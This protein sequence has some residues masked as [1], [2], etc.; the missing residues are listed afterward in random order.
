[1]T[2]FQSKRPAAA[3]PR[4]TNK[5]RRTLSPGNFLKTI[6]DFL[7]SAPRLVR[8]F[9][10]P[11][12]PF[13]LREKIYLAVTSIN[14]CRFCE[15]GHSHW[16]MAHGMSLDAVNEVLGQESKSLEAE[17]SAEAVAILFARHY[18]EHFDRIDPE[19]IKNLRTYYSEVQIKEIL[20]HVRFITLTNLSG[21][22]V[23][24]FLGR[25]RR[26]PEP[27]TLFQFVAGA[28]LAPVLLTII[29][30]A[31]IDHA[32]GL[33]KLRSSWHRTHHDGRGEPGVSTQRNAG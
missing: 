21:N 18:A 11:K 24:A 16:A 25:F 8:A 26:P 30:L 14:D 2:E 7:A 23:D 28:A 17:N 13:V 4:G 1:M 3:T 31:K 33:T 10:R 32:L 12:I 20:A 22:T 6:G 9:I 15:W 5:A 19:S 27:V 29:I